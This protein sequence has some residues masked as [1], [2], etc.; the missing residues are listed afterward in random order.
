VEASAPSSD[1]AVATA[2]QDDS[3]TERRRDDRA[4]DGDHPGAARLHAVPNAPA[5][6]AIIPTDL[7]MAV[8]DGALTQAEA[9]KR[10]GVSVRTLQRRLDSQR[11]QLRPRDAAGEAGRE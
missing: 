6:R 9:A 10:A 7:L 2:N 1:H 5:N 8:L 3:A 4:S 11:D